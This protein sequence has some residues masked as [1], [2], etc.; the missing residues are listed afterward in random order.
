MPA[1]VAMLALFYFDHEEEGSNSLVS[2]LCSIVS[3]RNRSSSGTHREVVQDA[4]RY[5]FVC[6]VLL[7]SIVL[8]SMWDDDLRRAS[9]PQGAGL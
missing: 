2:P 1:S 6:R 8:S 5:L 7:S 9:S 4:L 3:E